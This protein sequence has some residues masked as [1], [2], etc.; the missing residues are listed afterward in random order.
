MIK[1][2]FRKELFGFHRVHIPFFV[3]TNNYLSKMTDS[4][5]KIS[6]PVIFVNENS[7]QPVVNNPI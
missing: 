7:Q 5:K 6:L 3:K 2:A 1:T 4:H